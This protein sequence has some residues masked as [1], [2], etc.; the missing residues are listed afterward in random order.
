MGHSD[1]VYVWENDNVLG[2]PPQS[3]GKSWLTSGQ[4][5]PTKA[6]ANDQNAQRYSV[7]HDA[8]A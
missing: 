7:S 8:S 4:I 5:E 3:F 6:Y 2:I 1:V